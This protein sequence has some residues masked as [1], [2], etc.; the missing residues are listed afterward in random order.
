MTTMFFRLNWHT[1]RAESNVWAFVCNKL[2][3]PLIFILSRCFTPVQK[4]NRNKKRDELYFYSNWSIT[5]R[6][7]GIWRK[8]IAALENNRLWSIISNFCQKKNV[9]NKNEWWFGC[10]SPFAATTAISRKK[11]SYYF[12]IIII[13]VISPFFS[14]LIIHNIILTVH[15]CKTFRM[16]IFFSLSLYVRLSSFVVYFVDSEIGYNGQSKGK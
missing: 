16:F 1:R 8:K 2:R 7:V 10:L 11:L 5:I 9:Y 12:V 14:M 15:F 13:Y 4:V 6:F 3:N